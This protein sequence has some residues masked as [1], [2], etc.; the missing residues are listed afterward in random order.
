MN[1]QT[2]PDTCTTSQGGRA[3]AIDVRVT[4]MPTGVLYQEAG[5]WSEGGYAFR[6]PGG[7]P[8]DFRRRP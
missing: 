5:R 6:T 3:L 2:D 4:V 7:A 8:Y 1:A